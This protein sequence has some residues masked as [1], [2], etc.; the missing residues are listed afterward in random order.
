MDKEQVQLWN[1]AAWEHFI[2]NFK[3]QI[4]IMLGKLWGNQSGLGDIF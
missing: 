1:Q 2:P 4:L 3:R